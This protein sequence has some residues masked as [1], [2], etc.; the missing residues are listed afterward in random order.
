MATEAIEEGRDAT[1]GPIRVLLVGPH[2]TDVAL[3]RALL[4]HSRETEVALS[5]AMNLQHAFETLERDEVDVL[6]MDIGAGSPRE[7]VAVSQARVRAPLVP[8]VVLV[9]G[10]DGAAVLAQAA[11]EVEPCRHEA[12]LTLAEGETAGTGETPELA[13]RRL[14][15]VDYVPGVAVE[16]LMDLELVLIEE[17]DASIWADGDVQVEVDVADLLAVIGRR[18][19]DVAV[20]ECE[21]TAWTGEAEHVVPAVAPEVDE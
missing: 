15:A 9:D 13:R 18:G 10:D 6:L 11:Q 20:P 3:L 7:L 19:R 4:E 12:V 2:A 5:H 8:V 17:F 16:L 21:G 1:P 14:S